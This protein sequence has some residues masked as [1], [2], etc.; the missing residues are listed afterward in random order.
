[1]N[2]G[3][4]WT[5]VIVFF[6]FGILGMFF[7]GNTLHEFSHKWDYEKYANNEQ[8]CILNVDPANGFFSALGYYTFDYNPQ[9]TN[10]INSIKQNTEIKAW[11]LTLIVGLI[12]LTS[13]YYF[14]RSIR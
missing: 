7:V 6:L 13:I 4:K 1:M 2:Q 9:Y 5:F 14:A 11:F 10:E 8:M 3:I 12:F